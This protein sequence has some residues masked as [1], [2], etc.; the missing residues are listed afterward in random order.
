MEGLE[1]WT[2][3]SN[4]NNFRAFFEPDC[5]ESKW[6]AQLFEITS[7][8]SRN[9]HK[10]FKTDPETKE[11]YNVQSLG[12]D[13]NS[14]YFINSCNGDDTLN[15]NEF[16][17]NNNEQFKSLADK[18]V[19]LQEQV[20]QSKHIINDFQKGMESIIKQ[21]RDD[22]SKLTEKI[23]MLSKLTEAR[24]NKKVEHAPKICLIKCYR[25]P[26]RLEN[27]W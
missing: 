9:M 6:P 17:N 10:H 24:K 12:P 18:V 15:N 25:S 8:D 23:R 4:G 14:F 13:P 7:M 1:Q 26:Q 22:F 20:D 3:S 11:T 5:S 19:M 21:H 27:I 2:L 16:D